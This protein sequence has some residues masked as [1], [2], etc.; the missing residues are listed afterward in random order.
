MSTITPHTAQPSRRDV[1]KTSAVAAGVLAGQLVVPQAVHAGGSELLRVGLI[2]CGGRGTGAAIQALSADPNAILVAMGDAFEDR[3]QS[4]LASLRRPRR[5]TTQPAQAEAEPRW[6]AQVK[7]DPD[8]CFVGLDAYQKVID[9]GVDVVLLASPPAFR[10]IHLKAAVA[11]GK[12]VFCE[13]PIAVDAPGVRSV[14]ETAEEAQ[15]KGLSLVSGF[16]W[17]YSL[18][19]RAIMRRIHDGAVGQV[20][21]FYGTYN[22]GPLWMHPRQPQWTDLEWQLRNWLYFT[23]LSGDHIVEQCVHEIDKMAWVMNDRSPV[24]AWGTGGRQVRTDPAYGHIYDHFAVVY[25]WGDGVRGFIYCRQQA[26]CANDVSNHIAGSAGM[27]DIE[28]FRPRHVISGRESWRYEGPRNNMYQQ[29][30]DELFRSIRDGKPMNDGRFMAN[31]TMIAILGRMA[32]Y[33]G[34]SVSWEMAINSQESLVPRQLEWGPMPMPEV[35]M[36]GRTKLV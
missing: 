17:R 33:T 6:A 9:S 27:A 4:S 36:P 10:P 21:T 31:S 14:L 2:G 22:T 23:W 30:H 7:V 16:C 1:L 34:Q 25:E 15:R 28:G 18:P 20:H 32:A 19:E 29:E 12:H 5:A 3:L 13:K 24:C 35:A 26:G 11:A 8:H